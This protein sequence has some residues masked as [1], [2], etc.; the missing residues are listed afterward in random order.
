MPTKACILVTACNQHRNRADMVRATWL[1]TWRD[2]IDVFFV[3]G[4][5]NTVQHND[6]LV[7]PVDDS[8][9]G[10]PAKI[11]VSHKWALEQGYDP[12]MK[13]DVDV[14]CHL[15]R[16]LVYGLGRADY[17]G[18][19]FYDSFAMGAFYELSRK[20]T[21][22]LVNAPLPAPF[23]PGGDDVWVGKIMAD[24]GVSR[25]HESRY[26]I[27]DSPNY[28]TCFSLHTS[29]PPKLDMHEIH[30]KMIE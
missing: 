3:Y 9:Y 27:G 28:D 5:G 24:A 12:I 1:N 6:E 15:P 17:V 2:L 4:N 23:A 13:T 16:I 14:Y 29:G 22:I 11:Q 25:F 10:L 19:F 7:F 26:Y 21:E 18:N 8:Y 30:R 20:A